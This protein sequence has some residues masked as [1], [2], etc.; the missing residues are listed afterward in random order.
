MHE[1]EKVTLQTTVTLLNSKIQWLSFKSVFLIE[2]L[3]LQASKINS[4]AIFA[5]K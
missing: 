3:F 2:K 5:L 1:F 4:K